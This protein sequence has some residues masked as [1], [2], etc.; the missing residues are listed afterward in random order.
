MAERKSVLLRMSPELWE[1]IRRL[2]ETD[3]RSMNAEIE[4]LLRE[5]VRR[6]TGRTAPSDP[7]AP[8]DAD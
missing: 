6:R 8:E 5:A 7:D 4:Y 2:A 3:L 1:A